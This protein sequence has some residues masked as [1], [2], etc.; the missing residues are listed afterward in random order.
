MK[1]LYLVDASAMFFRAYYAVRPLS[2][3]KGLPTNALYGFLQMTVKLLKDVKPDYMVYCFDRKE[4]SFRKDIYPEYKANR[5]EMPENLVPQVPYIRKLAEV[6]GIPT[7]DKVNFEADDVI[8]TLTKMGENEK[9]NVVIVS[10]DKDFAQLLSSKTVLYDTMKDIKYDPEKA[11]EKWGVPPEQMIDYLALVGDSSDNVPGVRGIGPKG[12]Q[13]LLAEFGSIENL[14]ER[15]ES[16]KNDKLREKLLDAKEM[17][18]LSKDLVTIRTDIDLGLGIEDLKLRTIDTGVAT[19]LLEE[20]EFKSFEKRLFGGEPS[21]GSRLEIPN[22][23][24]NQPANE[25]EVE[26]A[27]FDVTIA[28]IAEIKKQ[29]PDGATVW[30]FATDRGCFLSHESKI[31]EVDPKLERLAETLA[32]KKWNWKGYDL[33]KFWRNIGIDRTQSADWDSHLAAYIVRSGQEEEFSKLYTLYVGAKLS[34]FPSPEEIL[35]AHIQLEAALRTRLKEINGEKVFYEIELPVLPVLAKME[36]DGVLIDTNLLHEQSLS[37]EKDIKTAEAAIH[38]M[39]GEPFNVASPKQLA[40]VLFDKL[41]LPIVKKTKTGPS[42]DSSV[43]EKLK[44]KHP[45]AQMIEEYRELSKL[46]STYVDAL[47]EL[48]DKETSRVHTYFNQTVAATGRLSS[49]N[50]NLQ[51]IPIRTERGR[52]IRKA[53]IAPKGTV[54]LSADYSQI[55]LRLLAHL[56]GDPGLTSAF[57]EGLDVHAATASEVFGIDIKDVNSDQ[58]RIAKAVNFGLAYGQSA[59]GLSETLGIDRSEAKQIVDNYFRKFSRVKDYMMEIVESAKEKGFVETVSGRRRYLPELQ[60][61]NGMLRKFG[62]RAAINAPLQGSASD[63]VKLAMIHIFGKIKG[64]MV[65][66]VHDELVFETPI[67]SLKDDSAIIKD[68][69]ESVLK[70]SVPLV[71]DIASG[72]NWDEAH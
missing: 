64:R 15:I 1:S 19:A 12:A 14:Y 36:M 66:Q 16:V 54:I 8:G 4:P 44:E 39:A 22:R 57:K 61:K 27:K 40:V 37:L 29:I 9:L 31:F 38:E 71:V 67:A 6:L 65:L 5:S 41:G 53:F 3:S 21:A 2:N 47:P 50:P 13:K 30:G 18:F 42:T 33:K 69:M 23:A 24:P 25:T 34:D 46:K 35:N 56:T 60:S 51:N 17:A 49:T 26:K 32:A 62:E 55:E 68:K 63:I 59:F 58:R 43:L 10:G 45:I 70:L 11:N 28:T 52:A 20:L 72:P 48:A 7:L